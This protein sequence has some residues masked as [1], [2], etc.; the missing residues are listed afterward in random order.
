MNTD[1]FS[2]KILRVIS[3]K[4]YRPLKIRRLAS[5]MGVADNEYGDYRETVKALHRAGRLIIGSGNVIMP[6]EVSKH[7]VGTFRANPKGFGFVIPESP[8]NHSD[9][10]IPPGENLGAVN[11][12]PG[13]SQYSEAR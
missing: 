3:D 6:P 4:D 10:Y 5:R 12:R 13:T 2:E 1:N 7:L 11:R 8:T 9:L